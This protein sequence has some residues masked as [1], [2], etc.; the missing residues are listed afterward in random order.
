MSAGQ[1]Q[2]IK[3]TQEQMTAYSGAFMDFREAVRKAIG[4]ELFEITDSLATARARGR[5]P[6]GFLT[7]LE[8]HLQIWSK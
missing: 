3:L 4:D 6:V 5:E 2:E 7:V 8:E 1:D